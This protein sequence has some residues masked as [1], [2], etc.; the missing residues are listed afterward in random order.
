MSRGLRWLRKYRRGRCLRVVLNLWWMRAAER[1]SCV[2]KCV[3]ASSGKAPIEPSGDLPAP[4]T[5]TREASRAV[6]TPRNPSQ[7]ALFSLYC[8]PWRCANSLHYSTSSPP[9]PMHHFDQQSHYHFSKDYNSHSLPR[10]G[11][12]FLSHQSRQFHHCSAT[13]GNQ[14]SGQSQRRR[15]RT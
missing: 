14:Y 9:L 10:L 2:A 7:G 12:Q 15:H 11:Y 3:Q 8:P 13:Y 5:T 6:Y 1:G 4:P